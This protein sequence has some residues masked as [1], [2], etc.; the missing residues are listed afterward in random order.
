MQFILIYMYV[1]V[2]KMPL[3]KHI[4]VCISLDVCISIYRYIWNQQMACF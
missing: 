4:Y 1:Y 2:V 3:C